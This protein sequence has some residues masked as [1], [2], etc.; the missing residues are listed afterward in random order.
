MKREISGLLAVCLLLF[1]VG[2]QSGQEAI[3]EAAQSGMA[4]S[5]AYLI[6]GTPGPDDPAQNSIASP[7]GG[8]TPVP[9]DTLSGHLLVKMYWWADP[10]NVYL[11][12][13]EFMKMHPGVTIDF[14]YEID[15]YEYSKLTLVE[16]AQRLESYNTRLRTELVSGEADYLLFGTREQVNTLYQLSHSGVL[17][18]LRPY[19]E[20]D[21]EIDPDDYFMDALNAFA[22]D[23]KMTVIPFSFFFDGVY[24]NRAI[25]D[26]LGVDPGDHFALTSGDILDWYEQARE[27]EPD[28]QLFFSAQGKETLLAQERFRRLNL[29][30]GTASFDS[31]EF[32]E[33]L[34][35]TNAVIA[36]DPELD[37]EDELGRSYGALAD[38]LLRY[39][40]TGREPLAVGPKEE[41]YN[42]TYHL[43]T[44][45][46]MSFAT[47][48]EV[49]LFQLVNF[50]QPLE[51][52]AGP[53]PLTSTDGKLGVTTGEDFAVPSGCKN[54]DLAWEFLK[55]C[56]SDREDLT[57]TD[58]GYYRDTYTDNIPLNRHI[59][60][61]MVEDVPNSVKGIYCPGYASFE[62]LD[63]AALDKTMERIFALDL[64]NAKQYGADV[65]DYLEEYYEKGLTTAEQCAKKVQDR[66]MIWLGE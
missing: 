46:R 21:P 15:M 58:V 41:P 10:N 49:E 20:N 55:Y 53:F 17:L 11:L 37:P 27:T 48:E 35:R 19:W 30:A 24:L 6:Q 12:A 52:M 61:K 38:E 4:S 47:A 16:R 64:V 22:V 14:D 29:E 25:L 18:D 60:A 51:Y 3:Y 7:S 8:I 63:S 9:G 43:A 65:G 36:D 62:P 66:A 32:V 54:P 59:F 56:L 5:K 40:A 44:V 26:S 57:F 28:L 31:P 23:G 33:F 45:G 39:R 42:Q 34:E 13:Q 50:Q 1:G 2:C